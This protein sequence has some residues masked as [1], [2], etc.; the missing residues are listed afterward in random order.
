MEPQSATF[1]SPEAAV[2]PMDID[3]SGDGVTPRNW[4]SLIAVLIVQAQ[5]AFNDNFVKFVLLG[6]A[7]AA[8]KGGFI[9]DNIEHI[10][11][12]MIPIPFILLAPV[13]GY[14]SD[15][16]SKRTI[17]VISLIGQLTIFALIAI[18]LMSHFV[19]GALL[20][21]FLLAVQSTVFSPAKQGIL[22]ELI[23]SERLGFANGLMQM[24]TMV[25]ILGG[26]FLG[27]MFFT[28]LNESGGDEWRSALI[29]T[30]VAGLAAIVPLVLVRWIQA[31]PAHPKMH[32]TR[33]VWGRHF[34]H[35]KELFRNRILR[36]T[37]LA[38]SS[39]WFLANFIG[40][41]VIG[42][43]KEL[44]PDG[45]PGA[46][47]LMMALI[48]IGLIIG[49]IVVS[50]LSRHRIRLD[51]VPLGVAG[52]TA[53]LVALGTLPAGSVAWN[54]SLGFIGFSSGFLLV[55]LNAFLQ[56]RAS[57]AT[58]GRILSANNLLASFV[59][60]V[61]I[62]IGLFMTSAL[63]WEASTQVLIYAGFGSIILLVLTLHSMPILR[64]AQ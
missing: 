24:L 15:R 2:D 57:E 5:N 40:L 46:S 43:G 30:L 56:D 38:I 29:P 44:K 23:G 36:L 35:L 50:T 32:F 39:Y 58:R 8:F 51:I 61:S 14:L 6:L 16:Y 7:I 49:S 3:S 33:E 10:L 54:F 55:P 63:D 4:I 20:G 11:G 9:G 60:L 27:G 12:A 22:K 64:R 13:A 62:A 17:I 42:F 53:G 1:P 59:G 34:V 19:Y 28:S 41:A 21:Y 52:I 26:M 45:A 18:S 48:G 37:S 47:A 31:T 25:G